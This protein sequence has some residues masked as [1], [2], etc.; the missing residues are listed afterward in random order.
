LADIPLPM[1]ANSPTP[2]ATSH[3]KSTSHQPQKNTPYDLIKCNRC[4]LQLII[5]PPSPLASNRPRA[6]I[7]HVIPPFHTPLVWHHNLHI[8]THPRIY[9]RPPLLLRPLHLLLHLRRRFLRERAIFKQESKFFERAAVGFGKHE[10][11]RRVRG[12]GDA[13][14]GV[15]ITVEER[16]RGEATGG[17]R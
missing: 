8:P 9:A 17:L 7:I 16:E 2:N 1:L 14:K 11:L 5:P 10:I 6:C 4:T 13:L 12:C 3:Q 15:R